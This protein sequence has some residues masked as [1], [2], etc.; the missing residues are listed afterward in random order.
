[1]CRPIL[2]TTSISHPLGTADTPLPRAP[3]GSPPTKSRS[4]S[5]CQALGQGRGIQLTT[6]WCPH[7]TSQTARPSC[8]WLLSE[9]LYKS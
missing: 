7:C 5:N 9:E 2:R 1:M 4:F 6:P 3:S 8:T